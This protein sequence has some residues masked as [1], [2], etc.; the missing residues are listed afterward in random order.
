[1]VRGEALQ[2]APVELV[3]GILRAQPLP[4]RSGAGAGGGG[5]D[6]GNMDN[7]FLKYENF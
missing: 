2:P 3:Q 5:R 7:T 1:M 4:E 6:E